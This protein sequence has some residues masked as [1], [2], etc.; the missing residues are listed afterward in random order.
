MSTASDTAHL[1]A[2]ARTIKPRLVKKIVTGGQTG[3]DRAA[4]DFAL[5]S[6]IPCG[7]WC[8]KGRGA[9]DGTIAAHY[10]LTET[11][12]EDVAQRT[13]WNV[14]DSDGTV[15]LSFGAPKDGTVLT[16]QMADQYKRPHH[17]IDMDRELDAPAFATWLRSNNIEIL[18]IAGPRESHSP[19]RVYSRALLFLRMLSEAL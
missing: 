7:G 4:L 10:P 3:V 18:N 6:S 8:P 2:K 11:P 12:L 16:F 17:Y 5:E 14:R 19:G 9:E 13:E 15:I 1:Q